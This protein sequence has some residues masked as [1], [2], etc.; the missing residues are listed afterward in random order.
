VVGGRIRNPRP[1]FTVALSD[2]EKH[3]L[4]EIERAFY[5]DD[6][7]FAANVSM[8]RV[9]RRRLLTGVAVFCLGVVVLL[10]GLV[11]TAD[12]AVVGIVISVAGELTMLGAATALYFRAGRRSTTRRDR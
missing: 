10:T 4:D 6:P 5:R 1:E 7:E 12:S 3:K 2:N 11:G 8:T 9:R